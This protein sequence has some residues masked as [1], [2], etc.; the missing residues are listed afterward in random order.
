MG[1]V[2]EPCR[3]RTWEIVR[4]TV[5]AY[6]VGDCPLISTCLVVGEVPVEVQRDGSFYRGH[7]DLRRYFAELDDVWSR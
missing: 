2:G 3:V 7:D 5:D 6:N 1:I 4:R